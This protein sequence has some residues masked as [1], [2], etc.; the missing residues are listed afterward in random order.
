MRHCF[1]CFLWPSPCISFPGRGGSKS[2]GLPS[3]ACTLLHK[4]RG[5]RDFGAGC[6]FR[7]AVRS[8]NYCDP[9]KVPKSTAAKSAATK[10]GKK[11]VA[12]KRP[13]AQQAT[14]AGSSDKKPRASGDESVD[15]GFG[16]VSPP[17]DLPSPPEAP[18]PESAPDER[19]DEHVNVLTY[20][21]GGTVTIR[22]PAG[23]QLGCAKCRLNQIGCKQCRQ[24]KG[25]SWYPDEKTW[26]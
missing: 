2:F 17:D 25:L 14:A 15:D 19:I 10:A 18:S 13:A 16:C 5:R 11:K 26:R 20:Q 8:S 1:G 7:P 9:G 23:V 24:K 21:R 4:S 6:G 12:M 22:V 3:P